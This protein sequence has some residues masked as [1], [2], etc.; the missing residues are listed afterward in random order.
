M[1]ASP[2]EVVI[3]YPP[4][5]ILEIV[6]SVRLSTAGRVLTSVVLCF[7]RIYG[8]TAEHSLAFAMLLFQGLSQPLAL[9]HLPRFQSESFH[10][11]RP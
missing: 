9:L 8:Q 4:L 7:V 5:T 11:R 3:A 2:P 10:P 1:Q 6:R